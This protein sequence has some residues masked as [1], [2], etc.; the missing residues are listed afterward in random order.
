MLATTLGDRP[1]S[2]YNASVTGGA[3]PFKPGDERDGNCGFS[4]WADD[5]NTKN[6]GAWNT[7]KE[8]IKTIADCAKRCEGCQACNFVSFS[9]LNEDCSWY[10]SCDLSSLGHP[11]ASYTS[12]MVKNAPSPPP[13]HALAMRDS[14]KRTV[15]LISKS[16]DTQIAQVQG[17]GGALA[18]VLEGVGDEP[19]FVPPISRRAD[20]SGSLS[21]GPFAVA[22]LSLPL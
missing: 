1:R 14:Q 19:G 11:G 3:A 17:A 22:L 6:V 21:L 16:A 9:A 7:T 20:A 8:G 2:L 4:W 15:L 18:T 13:F 5:C 12:E 10:K